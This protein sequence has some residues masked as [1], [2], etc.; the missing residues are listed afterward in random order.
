MHYYVGREPSQ[1]KVESVR[2]NVAPLSAPASSSASTIISAGGGY[3][4]SVVSITEDAAGN[5]YVI[6][7]WLVT[8]PSYAL[9]VVL[10]PAQTSIVVSKIDPTGATVYVTHLGGKGNDSATGIAVDSSGNVFGVGY[11]SS[12]DFPLLHAAQSIP[13]SRKTGF[14]FKLDASGA[15][16][17]STYFGG[18]DLGTANIQPVTAYSVGSSVNAVAADSAG[19]A[20]V[21]GTSDQPNLITTSGAFQ[22]KGNVSSGIADYSS[23]F[24]AKFD[25]SGMLAY[26]T[27]LGG[28]NPNC[29]GGSACIGYSKTDAAGSIAVDSAGNAYV[30]GQ[31]NSVDFPTTPGAF[32]TSCNCPQY[33][34][35]G[36][37]TKLN[38]AGA[39]LVYSTYASGVAPSAIVLDSSGAVYLAGETTPSFPMPAGPTQAFAGTLNPA[40]SALTSSAYGGG[41]SGFSA[42]TALARDS[43]GHVFLSGKTTSPEF[44]NSLPDFPAG[45]NFLLGLSPDLTK[46]LYSVRIPAGTSDADVAVDPSTGDLMAAG[47]SGDLMRLTSFSAP[48]P[49]ILGVGNAANWTIDSAVAPREV[50]SIYGIGIGPQQP[51]T[52]QPSAGVYPTSLGGVQVYFNSHPAPLLY[53]S[54]NQ[55][56]TVVSDNPFNQFGMETVT[57]VLNDMQLPAFTLPLTANMPGIF[58]NLD[59]SAIALNQDGTLNSQ[60]NS[61][62]AGSVITLWGTGATALI[63][64]VQGGVE[65]VGPNGMSALQPLLT[66]FEGPAPNLIQG[67][68]QV[69]VQLPASGLVNQPLQILAGGSFSPMVYVWIAP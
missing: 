31:T 48:L 16:A 21:T 37:V 54:A 67:V 5:T 3:P 64:Q 45:Q 41:T 35:D 44:P 50:V 36:F 43:A 24:V 29:F 28:S 51:V 15:L 38:P 60:A 59:A 10:P 12:P 27:W 20:Y 34:F 1:W 33:F 46:V 40:G 8:S 62:K 2:R 17:W 49:P 26:S 11:T 56:N 69:Q 61:A 53:V 47:S 14:V 66:P 19:D 65:V 30:A 39:G 22:T 7:N 6:G 68:F 52:A 58:R 23:A 42:A 32:Q 9:F 18:T 57:V 55:I 13:G 25:P 63:E 4:V